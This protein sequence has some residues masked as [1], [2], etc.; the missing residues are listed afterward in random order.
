M[1][2]DS[3]IVTTEGVPVLS[4]EDIQKLREAD[5]QKKNRYKIVAQAGGQENMLST[6]ADILIGGG[7]RGGSKTFSLILEALKDCEEEQFRGIFFRKEVSDLENIEEDS[8]GVFSDFGIYN[9]SKGDMTWNFYNGGFLKLNYYSD[10]IE[11]FRTRFQGKQ[12]SLIGVDE[13]TQMEYAKFKY[14][15]TCNRNAHGIR[16]RFWGTCNPDPDSWVAEFISWWIG[17]NGLPIPERN[18][19][20]R[21]C[22][23]EGDDVS[24]IY[25]GD[26]R[27]GVYEQCRHLIDKYW[28]ESFREYGTP[29]ELFILS[30]AFVEAKLKDNRQLMRSDPGYLS[31]LLNQGEEQKARDLEGNWKFKTVGDDILKMN[32]MEK[33]FKNAFQLGDGVRRASCDIAYEGGDSLVLWLWIGNHIQDLFVCKLD[34]KKTESSVR[35]KLLEWGVRE[36]NFTYD[37]NG[38]GQTFKGYFPKAVP[39]NNREAVDDKFKHIYDNLKSQAAYTL[40]QKIIEL[41]I[42]I[43]PS[44][45][46]RKYSGKGFSNMLLRQILMNERKSIRSNEETAD[47]GFCLIKKKDMKRLVGHSPDYFEALLMKMIFHIKKT[48]KQKPKGLLRYV[49]PIQ[50][51]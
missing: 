25:W 6:N 48:N 18:G 37:L 31:K 38:L 12:Y 33:F 1:E 51:R 24:T 41:E 29:Q 3:Y 50:M 15:I 11:D 23:M 40:A 4:Y 47:K 16:N 34:S 39:F 5:K 32:H 22:F 2:E 8:K 46:D 19:V 7:S 36:E 14:I 44:L 49:S 9:R 13:V 35:A 26:T 45:L 20:V 17:E 30:V 43:E 28:D 27:E 21:Y 42:S 10:N